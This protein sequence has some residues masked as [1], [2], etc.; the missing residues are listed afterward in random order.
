MNLCIQ[1]AKY[2]VVAV[3]RIILAFGFC[4]LPS[5]VVVPQVQETDLTDNLVRYLGFYVFNVPTCKPPRF[6]DVRWIHI[7]PLSNEDVN[8]PKVDDKGTTR[9]SGYLE[10][11]SDVKYWF[12]E[13]SL[14]KN[15]DGN[16]QGLR[17]VTEQRNGVSFSFA[18][19]FLDRTISEGGQY[20]FFRGSLSKLKDNKLSAY[21]P[22]L[23]FSKY[24]S[25]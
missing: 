6:E 16:F 5:T 15:K 14:T 8:E 9:I 24:E 22:I 3:C 21:T 13:A 18:G 10:T 17:F 7:S 19:D 20:T 23:P 1:I 12:V 25:H 2:F 4:L 11:T